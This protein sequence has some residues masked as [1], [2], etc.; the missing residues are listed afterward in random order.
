MYTKHAE[1]TDRPR[2]KKVNAI[3]VYNDALDTLEKI[4]ELLSRKPEVTPPLLYN[5]YMRK[6][7]QSGSPYTE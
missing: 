1:K 6:R 2:R 7:M 4:E 5:L 3:V